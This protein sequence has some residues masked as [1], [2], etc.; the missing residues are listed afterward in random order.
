MADLA[1]RHQLYQ[2]SVQG[3]EFELDY[4]DKVFRRTRGRKPR[5]FRED[6]CGT[7]L[8]A[9]EWVRRSPRNH[10]VGVDLDEGVLQWGREH[11]LAP[12]GKK[13]ARVRLLREDVLKV[14]TG[15]CDVCVAFNFSYWV[16]Q[17]RAM[18][19]KYFRNVHRSLVDDGI[20]FLD[21]YGG[22]EAYRTQ[23]ERRKLNGFTYVWDQAAF[24]PITG[25]MTCHIHFEF[26]DGSK[27]RKAFTYRWRLWGAQEIRDLLHE[28]G[29]KRTTVHIQAFDEDTDEPLDEFYPTE[30]AEDYATWIG[31]IV[32]EK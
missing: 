19:K 27:M 15:A 10:A 9:C 12:L 18:L 20:F 13:A 24:N 21:T 8:S 7:A 2:D 29:F 16:F 6:F 17:Q 23:K 28:A 5:N 32:A 30:E 25:D 1:D 22:Y 31:Y 11:N 26:P 3:V 4:I 14:D